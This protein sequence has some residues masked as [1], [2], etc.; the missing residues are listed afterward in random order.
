MTDAKDPTGAER[1]ADPSAEDV[2]R[3]AMADGLPSL[4][5]SADDALAQVRARMGLSDEP[6]TIGG[7]RIVRRLGAGAMGVVYLAE[8]DQLGRKV[9]IKLLAAGRRDPAREERLIR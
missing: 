1:T 6:R 2:A 3:A 9:A 7:Y 5:L 4:G 8:D